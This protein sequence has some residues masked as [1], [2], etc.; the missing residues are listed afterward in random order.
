MGRTS[1]EPATDPVAL[2]SSCVVC[3]DFAYVIAPC[4]ALIERILTQSLVIPD[5][6]RFTAMLR[7]IFH[8]TQTAVEQKL[9]GDRRGTCASYIPELSAQSPDWFGMAFTSI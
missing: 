1:P 8:E 4:G 9:P 3:A 6:Q 5:W 2:R 7:G